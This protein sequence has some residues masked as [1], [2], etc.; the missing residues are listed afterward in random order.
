VI[1][2]RIIDSP[3]IQRASLFRRGSTPDG[4]TISTLP[5]GTLD[6]APVTNSHIAQS[7]VIELCQGVD[8]FFYLSLATPVGPD[9]RN[10]IPKPSRASPNYAG[11]FDAVGFEEAG[12]HGSHRGVPGWLFTVRCCH[13]P[14]LAEDAT[15][16]RSPRG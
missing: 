2:F 15:T 1:K 9:A 3:E 13:L 16:A 4:S 8:S 11:W 14:A 7:P 12:I 6:L 5:H 10:Q